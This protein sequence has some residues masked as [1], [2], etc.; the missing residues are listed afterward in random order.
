[1]KRPH[2][3]LQ[4]LISLF[5]AWV[6]TGFV[7]LASADVDETRAPKGDTKKPERSKP[8]E[9]DPGRDFENGPIPAHER[10]AYF[11]DLHIHSSWSL[12]A[13]AEGVNV[14]P[15]AAYRYARG[16]SI[17]HFSGNSIQLEGPPLDFMALTEHAEYLG[18]TPAASKPEHPIRKQPLIR[19]WKGKDI[20]LRRLAWKKIFKSFIDRD[21]L[22]ALTT[23]SIV[24][25]AWRSLVELANREN[26][27]GIFTTFVGFEYSPN[28]DGQNLHRNVILRGGEAPARP[29]SSMEST[30][31]EDLWDWMDEMRDRHG[32]LIAIPHNA[33][34][35]NGLMFAARRHDG[36][37]I[38]A[39]W[40]EQR[41]RNEP[42]AEAFQIKG[43][44][45]THPALS[46]G[47]EWASFEI[48]DWRSTQPDLASRPKGSYL[49]DAL[50]RGLQI[51]ARTGHNPYALGML[52]STDGHNASSPFEE[53]NYTGKIGRS[54]A[55]AQKRLSW[56]TLD[57]PKRAPFVSTVTRWGAAG[58]AGI[59]AEE[60]TRESLFDAIRRRETFATSGPRIRIRLFA[61]WDFDPAEANGDFAA[62]GYSRGVP[63]GGVLVRRAPHGGAS[64]A[65]IFLV[66]AQKDPIE[67]ELERLQIVKGWLVDGETHEQV[68][69]IACAKGAKPDPRTHRCPERTSEPDLET[70]EPVSSEGASEF[71]VAW[72]D[73][74]YT[75]DAAVFYYARVLQI[76]TCRWSTFDANRLGQ[77]LHTGVPATIQERAV[78]SPIWIAGG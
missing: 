61:G 43:Q 10:Q 35:S 46:P 8:T 25:P 64:P 6:L 30:N 44:S 47:D 53:R 26:Q 29:F 2:Q 68:F 18:L 69:D 31:P 16:E 56:M 32:D 60:N 28:P 14:G 40:A 12:D 19:S 50:K 77:P 20:D 11:G 38:D 49:R 75:P 72:R 36:R 63:M 13:F 74:A 17:P 23:D 27:P 7:V 73:P 42:V 52:G 76:P 39:E 65:P 37:P 22:P 3:L 4:K 58:L 59:W 78:T 9:T 70:C 71:S 21:V 41:A 15:M 55:T 54:D 24:G 62:A 1:M 5:L 34:G 67:A 48:A 57:H 66:A 51:E 45:E 33:N